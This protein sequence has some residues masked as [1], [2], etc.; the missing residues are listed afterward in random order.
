MQKAK[1]L[2]IPLPPEE[3]IADLLKVRP[4]ADMPRPS[5]KK[6]KAKKKK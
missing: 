5:N 2:S 1:T 3:A 6:P 4:T